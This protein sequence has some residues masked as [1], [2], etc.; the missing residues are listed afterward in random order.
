MENVLNEGSKDFLVSTADVAFFVN[1]MLAFTGTTSLNTS[2]SVSM[3]DQEITG[4]KGNKT[5]YKYK[6]GRKLAPSIEM[7]EWSLAYIAANVGSNIFEGLKNV[8]SVAECV[9]LTQG[10]GTLKKVPVGN[11]YIE[12]PDGTTA[13]ITPMDSTII[14]GNADGTVLATYQYSTNVKRVTIDAESTPFVGRLVMSADKHNNKKGKVGE[15]QIEV[16]SFQLN[17]TFDISLEASGSTTTKLEGDALAVDGTSCSDGSVYAYITEIPSVDSTITVSDL[18]VTPAIT[19][20]AVGETKSLNVVGI[21]GGLYS[22]VGIDVADCTMTSEDSSIATV[23]DG[24]ITAV[25]AGTTYINVDY[26]G[27]KDVVKVIVA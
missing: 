5:L 12:K 27:A 8:F 21:R 11:V 18:A 13:E 6:Y 1:D 16:P 26:N 3:E 7:A 17:G 4:G 2:I 22:N 9:T 15:V 23:A 19:T 24:V 25:A 14:V 20:L 10:V